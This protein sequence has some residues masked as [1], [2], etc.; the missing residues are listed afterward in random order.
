MSVRF[1]FKRKAKGDEVLII[2]IIYGHND[3]AEA[4]L[5]IKASRKIFDEKTQTVIGKTNEAKALAK[6]LEEFK[7]RVN[8][9]IKE[10]I[11]KKVPINAKTIKRIF[12]GEE[13][14]TT[15]ILNFIDDYIEESKEKNEKDTARNYKNK[16]RFVGL[17]LES[18]N[19][20][21]VS[22][23]EIDDY[24]IENFQRFL[25]KYCNDRTHER[26]HDNQINEV[27]R[28]FS[29]V[30][31]KAKKLK[32]IDNNPIENIKLK[33]GEAKNPSQPLNVDEF[34]RLLHYDFSNDEKLQMSKDMFVFAVLAGGIRRGD[35]VKLTTENIVK[36]GDNYWIV[37][38][39]SKVKKSVKNPLPEFA[40]AIYYKY[41]ERFAEFFNGRLFPIHPSTYNI[42]L[43][44]AAKSLNINHKKITSHS[45][46]HTFVS[47][48]VEIG[49]PIET[50][51]VMSGH[52][53]ISM[54][55]KHYTKVTDDKKIDASKKWEKVI[56]RKI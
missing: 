34:N 41:K 40:V 5:P 23:K 55:W 50:N 52:S 13:V 21:D 36:E 35:L 51:S 53:D 11:K 56:D 27:L 7:E 15:S 25:N 38:K 10:L 44:M 30:L 46:R 1:V 29:A 26:L 31:S 43:K 8:N 9:I 49:I 42:H 33:R 32:L 20:K 54:T 22:I 39:Q 6:D 48:N 24:F 14:N 17:Y 4:I 47:I 12:F 18:I 28:R 37:F 19:R 2:R 16:L 45:A 3:K